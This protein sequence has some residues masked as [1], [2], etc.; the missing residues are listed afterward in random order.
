ME[1]VASIWSLQKD[2]A[3]K[4]FKIQMRQFEFIHTE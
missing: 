3:K 1:I 4:L 2:L